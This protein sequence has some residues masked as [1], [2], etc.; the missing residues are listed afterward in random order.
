MHVEANGTR[1]E[2]NKDFIYRSIVNEAVLVPIHQ[3]VADMECIYTLNSLGA[4]IWERMAQ[5]LTQDELLANIQG[6]YDVDPSVLV[7]DLENF[8]QEMTT[9]GAIRKV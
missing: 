9:I 6:E 3:D 1:Y 7:V 8:I 2:R 5:P 4:F